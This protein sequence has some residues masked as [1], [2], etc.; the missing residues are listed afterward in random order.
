MGP[1]SIPRRAEYGHLDFIIIS[2][3]MAGRGIDGTGGCLF[4][5]EVGEAE[6]I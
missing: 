2:S 3:P 5:G 4:P 1:T 6:K